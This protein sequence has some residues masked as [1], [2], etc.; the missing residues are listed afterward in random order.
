MRLEA[1]DLRKNFPAPPLSGGPPFAALSGVTLEAGPG[2]TRLE[3]PNGSGKTT[4]LKTLAGVLEADGGRILLDGGPA[5]PSRLRREAAY[6]PAD[7]RSFYF[8]LT[9]AENL[10]FFGALAGLDEAAAMDRAAELAVALGLSREDL[11]KRFD[12]LSEGN[13]QKVSLIR[14]FSRG[15]PLLLLDEPFRGL[16]AEAREGLTGLIAAKAGSTAV[17]LAS[18]DPEPLRGCDGRALRLESGRLREGA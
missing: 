17:L 13:M 2:V 12:R 6:C 1:L 9:A 10:R 8:R 16:D 3:G 18:H 7:P 14:A 15:T 5:D 11:G 4:L